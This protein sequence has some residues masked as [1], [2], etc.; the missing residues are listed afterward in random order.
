MSENAAS[1]CN[2]PNKWEREGEGGVGITHHL[3][4]NGA[5][6]HGLPLDCFAA[7]R[8]LYL[9]GYNGAQTVVGVGRKSQFRPFPA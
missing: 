4:I 9:A 1:D 5:V 6:Y 3:S 8:D 7:P 2:A